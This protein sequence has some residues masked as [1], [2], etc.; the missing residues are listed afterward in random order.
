MNTPTP[1]LFFD[2][3]GVLADY[4]G[5]YRRLTGGD[6]SEKGGVKAKRFK[7]HP[8][9]YRHLPLLPGAMK[10]WN[11]A[12]PYHPKILS[13]QSNYVKASRQDK[14]EWVEEHLHLSGPR[15]VVVNYPN[16]KYKHCK[17]G[18][19]LVDDNAKNCEEWEK[20]GGVAIRHHD[21][22]KTIK[23]LKELLGHVDTTHVHEAFDELQ[24][25]VT[26]DNLAEAFEEL[27]DRT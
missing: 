5:E 25:P 18:A 1:E 4:E 13:A 21:V 17:P 14:H 16:D 23:R 24:K 2:L 9:F 8:H 3:D 10:M 15:V 19:I 11:F 22:D 6:P 27:I 26:C 7:D 12:L 20:A